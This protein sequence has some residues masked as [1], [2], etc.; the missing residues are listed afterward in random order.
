MLNV[1]GFRGGDGGNNL[2]LDKIWEGT[3]LRANGLVT[4]LYAIMWWVPTLLVIVW[5]SR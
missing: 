3:S 5:P 2:R 4:G 1:P